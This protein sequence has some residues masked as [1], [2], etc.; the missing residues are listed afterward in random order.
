MTNKRIPTFQRGLFLFACIVCAN[1]GRDVFAQDSFGESF[2]DPGTFE[3]SLSATGGWSREQ[4]LGLQSK[5]IGGNIAL[6][7]FLTSWLELGAKAEGNYH[8]EGPEQGLALDEVSK[9]NVFGGP[10]LTLNIPV[11]RIV[12]FATASIGPLYQETRTTGPGG[13]TKKEDFGWYWDAGGGFR[14]F[15][16]PYASLNLMALYRMLL[17]DDKP[18]RNDIV[19]M[20]GI[21]L[22]F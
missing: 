2:L 18:D 8:E 5:T 4:G 13:D 17:F 20:V 12:P 10:V 21:S 11:S 9:L 15:F 7:F 1:G 19:G 14:F 6:G 22:F 3:L 16:A